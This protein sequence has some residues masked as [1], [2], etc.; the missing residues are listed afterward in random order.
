MEKRTILK[1]VFVAS[2]VLAVLVGASSAKL[3]HPGFT[4]DVTPIG[5]EVCPGGTATYNV[6]VESITTETEY[7]N[8]TI[9]PE[10]TGWTYSFNP[11]GFDLPANETRY[12]ILGIGVPASATPGDYYH[13]VT[14]NA[15]YMGLLV[16]NSTYHNL[17]TTVNPGVPTYASVIVIPKEPN[18]QYKWETPDDTPGDGYTNVYPIP[19]ENVTVDKYVVVCDP[20]GKDDISNV[21]VRTFKPLGDGSACNCTPCNE[22]NCCEP[23]D[24]VLKEESVATALDNR[25]A[26]DDAVEAAYRTYGLLTADEKADIMKYLDNGTGWI[27]VEHNNFN[28]SDPAGNYT[29]CAQVFDHGGLFDCMAN[30]FEYLSI[31]ALAIDFSEVDYGN[32]TRNETKWVTPGNVKNNGNDPMDIVIESWN[33]TST[34]G[35]VIP[36]DKLDAKINVIEQWLALPPGV[37]FNVS[38]PGCVPT[39]IEFS[40]HVPTDTPEGDYTGCIRLT[41]KHSS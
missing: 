19:G 11:V 9:E 39:P 29:V 7:V 30:T 27:Y 28:C 32:V 21:V 33:M 4:M 38:L 37:L 6:S 12:S 20:D 10:Q 26:C 8:F 24:C 36:A 2:M 40:L 1:T 3:G 23:G 17:K 16:E 14:G 22:S 18:V 5:D 15:Y 34:G 25:T 41:G 31:I 13:N 35:G